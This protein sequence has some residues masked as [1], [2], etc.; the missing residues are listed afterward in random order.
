M[1]TNEAATLPVA[2]RRPPAEKAA[3]STSR[4][5]PD[6]CKARRPVAAS[7]T[8][9]MCSDRPPAASQRPSGAKVTKGDLTFSGAH[10]HWQPVAVSHSRSHSPSAEARS[11]PSGAKAN[12]TVAPAAWPVRRRTS[13]PLAGSHTTSAPALS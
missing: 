9:I 13:R 6:N 7:K 2:R 1:P 12:A 11:R 8:W 10:R 4:P 3:V 5:Q